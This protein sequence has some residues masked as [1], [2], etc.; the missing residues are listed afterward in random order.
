MANCTEEFPG[1]GLPR[2]CALKILHKANFQKRVYLPLLASSQPFKRLKSVLEVC[3][4][5]TCD[6]EIRNGPETPS[7]A[8]T[9]CLLVVSRPGTSRRRQSRHASRVSDFRIEMASQGQA[10]RRR[11][12]GQPRS[13]HHEVTAEIREH[14]HGLRSCQPRQFAR[15]QYRHLSGEVVCPI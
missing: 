9:E 10:P 15:P 4:I 11:S 13:H 3:E 6:A 8:R 2:A 7:P 12:L 1:A 14:G 5:K